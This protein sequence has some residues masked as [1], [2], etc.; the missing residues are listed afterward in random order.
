MVL[1]IYFFYEKTYIEYD[2]LILLHTKRLQPFPSWKEEWQKE[3]NAGKTIRWRDKKGC[4]PNVQNAKP[5]LTYL[6]M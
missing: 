5:N 6:K 3:S 2:I 1:K 4:K